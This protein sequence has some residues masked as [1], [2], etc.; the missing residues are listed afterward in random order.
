MSEVKVV[1]GQPL[2]TVTVVATDDT[3]KRLPSAVIKQASDNRKT[4]NCLI[5]VEN[6]PIRIANQV[7]PVPGVSGKQVEPGQDIKLN[8]VSQVVQFRYC[9][10]IAGSDATIHIYPEV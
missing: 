8:S 10:G 1:G 4:F 2:E 7:D 5:A 6:A 3:V 9:N